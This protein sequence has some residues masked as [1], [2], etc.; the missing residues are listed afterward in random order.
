MAGQ[1]VPWLFRSRWTL[2]AGL[3]LGLLLPML[4]VAGLIVFQARETLRH[5][6]ES[7]LQAATQLAAEVVEE[8]FAGQAQYV[9][10]FARRRDLAGALEQRDL[11]SVAG[12]L[13][14]LVAG[15]PALSRAF[16]TDPSGVEIADHP[17]VPEVIGQ[18]FAHRDWY[19]GVKLGER[20]YVS[21][22]Y[23]RSAEPAVHTVALATP[24][25]GSKGE[26]AGYLVAQ[27]TVESLSQRLADIR[28]SPTGGIALLDRYDVLA[29]RHAGVEGMPAA[30]AANATIQAA[31][32]SDSMVVEDDNPV[33]GE[34]SFLGFTRIARDGWL[35]MA[36]DPVSAVMAPAAGLQSAVLGWT[37]LCFLVVFAVSFSAAD[38]LRHQHQE[39]VELEATKSQVT[40]MLIHDLRSPLIAILGILD[41]VHA[42]IPESM[43]RLRQDVDMGTKSSRRLLAMISVLVDI[44]RMEE[45]EM[46]ISRQPHELVELLRGKLDE[47][48]AAAG[49]R[50]LTLSGRLPERS[51]VAN[52]DRDLIARVVDNLIA[53]AIQHTPPGG[54]V[55]VELEESPAAS[56]A[57][58]VR[59]RDTGEGIPESFLPR[60]FQKYARAGGQTMGARYD[61]GLGLVFCRMAVE[62]HGGTI[63]VESRV[64]VGTQFSI[65]LPVA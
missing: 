49:V 60:L 16:L 64:G 35:V 46:P 44:S 31:R 8:H 21:G 20:L 24:V 22:V 55:T 32:G 15:S 13:E 38:A 30:L 36:H 45:G 42:Q 25:R 4:G 12:I 41:L 34:P 57:V 17:H 52:V 18:S 39:L 33:T 26:V 5:Q 62:L 37:A 51:V 1:I 7:Q 58:T 59:V 29:S 14:E 2:A 48:A 65:A 47:Y 28:P 40:G 27:D 43:T 23:R 56:G 61:S 54:E 11:S 6:A 50:R 3:G 10:S 9:E 19:K 53:N 63:G